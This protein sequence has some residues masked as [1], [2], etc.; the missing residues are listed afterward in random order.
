MDGDYLLVSRPGEILGNTL[1]AVIL[2]KAIGTGNAFSQVSFQASPEYSIGFGNSVGLKNDTIIIGAHL[3]SVN[4]NTFEGAYYIYETDF[5]NNNSNL[6]L[7]N[8]T[9]GREVGGYMGYS[10]HSV[11]SHRYAAAYSD[12]FNPSTDISVVKKNGP[13]YSRY[14]TITDPKATFIDKVVQDISGD[15][16]Y[17]IV[18]LPHGESGN[19]KAGGRV[20]FGKVR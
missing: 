12:L 19:G 18:G 6:I 13:M 7:I 4:T 20:F 1:A 10:V 3:K 8:S 2:F 16:N 9:I 15:H 17:F 5:I 11:E 14:V